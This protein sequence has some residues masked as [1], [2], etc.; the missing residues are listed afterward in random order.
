MQSDGSANR[1][2]RYFDGVATKMSD[3]IMLIGRVLIASVFVLTAVTSSPNAGYL[4]SLHYPAP[5]FWSAVAIAVEWVIGAT[6]IL[7]IATRYGA[8]LALL[9]AIIAVATA[10]RYWEYPQ[11]QQTVQY[12]LATKDLSILGGLLVLFVT[13]AGRYSIDA[14]LSGKR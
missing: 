9:Y 12:I 11:A 14:L 4:T 1:A 7:G 10:H 8:V 5:E 2:L 13:G 6:L 3:F